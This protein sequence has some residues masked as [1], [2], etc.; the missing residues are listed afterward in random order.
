MQNKKPWQ[1]VN[2]LDPTQKPLDLNEMRWGDTMLLLNA[3]TSAAG[4]IRCEI[5]DES[6]QPI[7]G[8]TLSECTPLYG[9]D[10]ELIMTWKNGP[11][12]TSLAN[13]PVIL[14]FELR[15]ADIYSFRFGQP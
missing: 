4:D 1:L 7:P 5:R 11:D 9:D 10:L 13:R 15:D 6:N 8:F 3:S 2:R 14:H 12:V